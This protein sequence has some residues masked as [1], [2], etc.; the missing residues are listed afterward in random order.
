LDGWHDRVVIQVT[1]ISRIRS[2]NGEWNFYTGEDIE[3]GFLVL[4]GL[5]A[6]KMT[7]ADAVPNDMVNYLK[8]TSTMEGATSSGDQHW[9]FVLSIHSIDQSTT[10]R[11]M[12]LEVVAA[13]L[14]LE[15]PN[16]P[17]CRI[18]A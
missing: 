4:T 14:H 9:K 10:S 1:C 3:D 8:V 13:D 18:Q 17:G 12:I 11:E 16:S 6:F 15:D 2:P 7:P 5:Q